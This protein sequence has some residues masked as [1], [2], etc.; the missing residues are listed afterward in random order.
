MFQYAKLELKVIPNKGKIQFLRNFVSVGVVINC[1]WGKILG[2]FLIRIDT[3]TY[4]GICLWHADFADSRDLK[5][6]YK[7]ET[8][9]KSRLFNV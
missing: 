7:K 5:T 6:A 8:R 1:V 9:Q 3:D 2:F 4:M